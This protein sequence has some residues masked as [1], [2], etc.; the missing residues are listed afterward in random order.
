ME[1]KSKSKGSFVSKLEEAAAQG[2]LSPKLKLI[3]ENFY[4]CYKEAVEKG[5]DKGLDHEAQFYTFWSW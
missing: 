3:L 5:N 2:K 4:L 1:N